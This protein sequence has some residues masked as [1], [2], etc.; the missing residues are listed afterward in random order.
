MP[1]GIGP[2]LSGLPQMSIEVRRGSKASQWP[3]GR[4]CR[5]IPTVRHL[6]N[7]AAC[8]NRAGKRHRNHL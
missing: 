2:K 3:T 1:Q 4:R 7:A 5:S 6:Q 8:L